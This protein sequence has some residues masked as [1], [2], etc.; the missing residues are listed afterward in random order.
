MP[1]SPPALII[2]YTPEFKRNLRL[3]ARKYRH[4]RSD[5][6]PLIDQLQTGGTPGDQIMGSG[7]TLFKAR[8]RNR[9]IQ[10]GQSSGYRVIY[11]QKSSQHLILVTI[12]SKLDQSDISPYR[13]RQIIKHSIQSHSCPR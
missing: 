4:I 11:W 5:I 3:L 6:K 10:K 1:S 9:D 12:Y 8:V 13:I 7:F 2:D